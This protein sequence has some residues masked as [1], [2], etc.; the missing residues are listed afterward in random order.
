MAQLY[1]GNLIAP[2]SLY[3]GSLVGSAQLSGGTITQ[4]VPDVNLQEKTVD[5]VPEA[6][7]IVPDEGYD[8]MSSVTVNAMPNCTWKSGTTSLITPAFG[9][10]VNTGIVTASGQR[11]SSELV[12]DGSGYADAST[13]YPFV[14]KIDP[15]HQ[16]YQLPVK[17]AETITPQTYAQTIPSGQFLVGDQTIAAVPPWNYLGDGGE[18]IEEIYP[19]TSVLLKNTSFN[20]WTP[21]TTAKTIVSSSTLS[22]KAFTADFSQYEYF[23]R[24]R[25]SVDVAYKSGATLKVQIYRPCSEVWQW[26]GK[27]P[28]SLANIGSESFNGNACVTYYTASLLSYYNSSGSMT[29]TWSATYGLYAS[30]AACTF[31]SSTADSTTVTPKTP[32]WNARCSTTYMST[33]RASELDQDNTKLIMRGELW[34]I[35]KNGAVR[36]MLE[37]CC[38]IY[39]DHLNP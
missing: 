2:Q 8:A 37:H 30:V 18:L 31:A 5:A 22:S 13:H 35:K 34:R 26:I 7:T 10:D 12:L 14:A 36:T 32:T 11:T 6:Q 19:K 21:S 15:D 1:G 3:G 39:N 20:G 38:D 28:S 23:L 24:W 33:T 17:T 9:V 4:A 25:W 29:Y 27:R 16:T